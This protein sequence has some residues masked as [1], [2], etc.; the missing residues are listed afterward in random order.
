MLRGAEDL[1]K[2]FSGDVDK[3]VLLSLRK[4][5]Q[6]RKI[7]IDCVIQVW[8]KNRYPRSPRHVVVPLVN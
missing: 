7:D 6:D 3:G 4:Q 5:L 8:P 1:G 2:I